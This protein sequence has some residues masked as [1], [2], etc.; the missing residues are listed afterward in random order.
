MST[1]E[2]DTWTPEIYDKNPDVAQYWVDRYY[3]HQQR[4]FSQK[5]KLGAR[6]LPIQR[7]C[8]K[9]HRA[10]IET[11]RFLLG[12]EPQGVSELIRILAYRPIISS[13]RATLERIQRKKRANN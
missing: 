5:E 4:I 13:H 11:T 3:Y 12:C 8:K 10:M 2:I 1:E 7:D 6:Y 9:V